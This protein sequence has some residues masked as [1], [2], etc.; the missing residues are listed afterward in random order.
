MKSLH[1]VE[2]LLPMTISLSLILAPFSKYTNIL[3]HSTLFVISE[4]LIQIKCMYQHVQEAKLVEILI[5]IELYFQYVHSVCILTGAS[6]C[7]H[8]Y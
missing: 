7:G 1:I 3:F 4:H 2:K 5:T 6:W 8:V